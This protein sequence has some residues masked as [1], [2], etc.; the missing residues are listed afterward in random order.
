MRKKQISRRSFLGSIGLIMAGISTRG[1]TANSSEI[2]AP[3]SPTGKRT[4][5]IGIALGGG[6][7]KAL[8]H[9][10]MLEALDELGVQPHLITGCSMGA[11]I[12]ALYA[13]GLSGRDIR[14]FID[15]LV[16]SRNETWPEAL[17][18]KDVLEWIKFIDPELGTGGLIDGE[19]FIQYLHQE[20]QVKHFSELRIPLRIV[21]A[22]FWKRE[23]V[24]LDQGEL[25]PA[26]KAS[27]AFPGLFVPVKIGGRVLVDGGLVNPVPYDLLLDECDIT[28][29]VDVTGSITAPADSQPSFFD[30]IFNSIHIMQE[31]II[32]EKLKTRQ[33]D[34]FI[35]PAINGI[36]MLE[37]YKAETVY[38]MAAPAKDDLKRA[39]AKMLS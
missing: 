9:I 23:Q 7:A 36:R 17:M 2:Q 30:A 13:S 6:G 15:K 26:I 39:L 31:T 18:H 24:I 35:R 27:M 14:N 8:A 29:A 38:Q 25:L 34:I 28:I 32:T 3:G 10:P 16:A 12:G 37:F 1:N 22:D 21:A 4:K 5:R 33:P 11:V 20:I 19:N